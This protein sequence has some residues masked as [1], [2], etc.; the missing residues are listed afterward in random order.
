MVYTIDELR[1]RII[2]VTSKFGI[3]KVNLFGSYARDEATDKSDVD[4][5]IDREGSHIKSMFDIGG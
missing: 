2:P 4:I 3:S 1:D 5:V